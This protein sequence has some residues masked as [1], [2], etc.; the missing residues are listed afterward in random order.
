MIFTDQGM[1]LPGCD[2]TLT[3]PGGRLAPHS[4]QNG[5]LT[6]VGAPGTYQLTVQYPG[7]QTIEREVELKRLVPGARSFFE[8]AMKI[9]LQP[10]DA[11]SE[12]D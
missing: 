6:F 4:S 11:G 8:A 3:G 9:N 2:V 10:T 1:L 5:Q 12:T 7:F